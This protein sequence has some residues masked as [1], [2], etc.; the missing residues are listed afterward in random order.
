MKKRLATCFTVFLLFITV[1]VLHAGDTVPRIVVDV[2]ANRDF[3]SRFTGFDDLMLFDVQRLSVERIGVVLLTHAG[4]EERYVFNTGTMKKLYMDTF[5]PVKAK[6]EEMA[7]RSIRVTD[8]VRL[9]RFAL[10]A[11][12]PNK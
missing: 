7:A 11:S 12:P 5:I 1:G 8:A 6:R 10:S 2:V 4:F 9:A 3:F